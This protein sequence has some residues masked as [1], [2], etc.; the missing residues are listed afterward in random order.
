[1]CTCLFDSIYRWLS[2]KIKGSAKATNT[3]RGA[4]PHCSLGDTPLFYWTLPYIWLGGG[5]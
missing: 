3:W 2:D 5:R 1:M 4:M